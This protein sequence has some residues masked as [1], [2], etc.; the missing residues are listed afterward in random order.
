MNIII[1]PTEPASPKAIFAYTTMI[2]SAI[3]KAREKHPEA[4][5]MAVC[6]DD[7]TCIH[8]YQF[9]G[10][11]TADRCV[12]AECVK[13]KSQTIIYPRVVN[14]TESVETTSAS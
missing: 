1:T 9:T 12:I 10:N 5:K 3:D 11:V 14:A 2:Q 13:C 6:V 8:R 7:V 4:P